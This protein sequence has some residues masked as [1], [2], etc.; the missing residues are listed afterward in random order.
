MAILGI[1]S[2]ALFSLL[3]NSLF[4]L[5]KLE[6]LHR[7][8]LACEQVMN[9]IQLLQK[10][11]PQGSVSGRAADM[12]ADWT[13]SVSPWYP[14]NLNGQPDHA[15]MKVDV[16]LTWNARTGLRHLHLESLKP[17]TVAYNNYDFSQALDK[18]IPN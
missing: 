1:A 10:L 2:V 18:T 7:Y 8:Q 4:N 16:E 13:V 11:P 14:A 17:T 15:I 9:R 5:R 12:A 6:D 3:S